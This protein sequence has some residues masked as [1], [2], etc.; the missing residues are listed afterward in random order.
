MTYPQDTQPYCS[1]V[2]NAG[3][4]IDD[5]FVSS[6]QLAAYKEDDILETSPPTSPP[7][8]PPTSPPT[9]KLGEAGCFGRHC[10]DPAEQMHLCVFLYQFFY[11]CLYSSFG[12][13]FGVW[14]RKT[15][16]NSINILWRSSPPWQCSNRG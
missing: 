7:T 4:I 12:S 13:C 1:T 15:I 8:R 16:A 10:N 6:W 2:Q 3:S 14:H 5:I 11:V 9:V